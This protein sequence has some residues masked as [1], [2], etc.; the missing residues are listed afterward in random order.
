MIQDILSSIRNYGRALQL[1][2]QLRLWGYVLL[3]A[4]I[5]L[6]LL[7]GIGATAWG[8]SDNFGNWLV[9]WYPWDWGSEAV[10]KIAQVAGGL[11]V[12]ALGLILYKN[13]VIILA[14]PFMSP[15]SEKV[16]DHLRGEPSGP[17]FTVAGFLSDFFRGLR[18]GVRNIVRELFFTVL[19]LLAGLIPIFSPVS[20]F[21][22]FLV[23]S[24][25]AGFGNMDYTLERHFRVG[26]SVQFV[27]ANAGL[28]LGNGIVFM[29]LLLIGIGFLI[30]PPLATVAATID[31]VERL[32]R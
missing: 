26:G 27:R 8:M 17:A 23:Q 5:S 29:G 10:R 4:L 28:A 16:E 12:A 3:P 32:E 31:T 9:S 14:G 20:P 7:A 11:T 30:A 13:L 24:Y 25:Y 19:L 15:L 22:I 1:I 2:G 21:A 6:A 18:I